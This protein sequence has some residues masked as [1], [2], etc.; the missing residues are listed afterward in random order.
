MDSPTVYT[1]SKKFHFTPDFTLF[2]YPLQMSCGLWTRVNRECAG[3]QILRFSLPVGR[4]PS[5]RRESKDR[6]LHLHSWKNTWDLVQEIHPP[7]VEDEDLQIRRLTYGSETCRLD[8]RTRK[9]LNDANSRLVTR[10]T[11]QTPHKEASV[12]TETF[13]IVKWIRASS[14][15]WVD[16]ILWMIPERM[17][18]Q[19]LR[20]IVPKNRTEGDLLMDVPP[21]MSWSD[22]QALTANRDGWRRRVRNLF[23]GPKIEITVNNS[24][25]GRKAPPRNID[26]HPSP[27]ECQKVYCQR[28]PRS[29]FQTVW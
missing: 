3:F 19:T 21:V 14:L 15:Q 28:L 26:Q 25:P 1:I 29:F 2:S 4:Q 6:H 8:A 22:L 18:H 24:L 20:H 27:T 7:E 11:N 23:Y 17:V 12:K 9:M 16:H 13:D 10:I 5:R